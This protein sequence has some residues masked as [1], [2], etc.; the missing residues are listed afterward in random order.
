MPALN[1]ALLILPASLYSLP[2]IL[3]LKKFLTNLETI[4]R[5]TMEHELFSRLTTMNIHYEAIMKRVNVIPVMTYIV[6]EVWVME[7]S[8]WTCIVRTHDNNLNT[9]REHASTQ[10]IGLI[11]HLKTIF[12]LLLKNLLKHTQLI[13]TSVN[14]QCMTTP[15]AI[16][17][18]PKS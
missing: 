15:P 16:P 10:E 12:R 7:V 5:Y 3:E 6:H 2:K 11:A 18:P 9:Y 13:R 14:P 4:H 17:N 8:T 1:K